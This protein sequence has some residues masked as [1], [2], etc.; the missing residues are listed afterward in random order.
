MFGAQGESFGAQLRRHREA[1]GLTQEQLAERAGLTVNGVSQLE[2]GERRRPYPHTV[3]ALAAALGLSEP[4]RAA[5][6]GMVPRRGETAPTEPVATPL[7]AA[8][9]AP[10]TALL[11][12]E[13]DVGAVADLLREARLVTLTGPGGVGKTRLGLAV[14][15]AIADR[16]PNSVAFVPLAALTDPALVVPAIA[17]AVGVREAGGLSPGDALHAALRARRLL[18]VLDNVEHLLAAV[19]AIA[20]L[21]AACPGLT[22]LATSRAPLRVRGEREYPVAPL[23]A[24]ALER[25]PTAAEVAAAPAARL[26]VERARAVAPAFALSD[27]NAAAVAAI[28]RRLDGLPLA[29]ELAAGWVRLLPPTA[30]LARLDRALPL[31]TAGPRDLPERQ[32][33]MR[34]TVAWSY[35]LLEPAE[36]RLFRRLAVFAGGWTLAAAE[37]V[38]A[39]AAS[40]DDPAA[41]HAL[42]AG[43]SSLL[44]KSLLVQSM[45]ASMADGEATDEPRFS[46]LETIRAYGLEQLAASGEEK[47]VRDRHA[48]HYLA[49]AEVAGPALTGGEQAAWLDRLGREHDNL[50]A[51]LDWLLARGHAE[52][53]ARLGWDLT[54]FWYIRGHVSEGRR[55]MER[56]LA[57][58]AALRPAGRARALTVGAVLAFQQGDFDEADALL[59]ESIRL[60]RDAGDRLVLASALLTRGYAAVGRGEGAQAVAYA[61]ESARLFRAFG[62]RWGAGLALTVGVQIATA[63]GELD[64]ANVDLD[65]AE[66]LLRAAGAPWGLALVLNI[67]VMI[68]Q[69]QGDHAG[70]VDLLR[71]SIGLSRAIGD[72][73]ALYFGLVSLGGALT[74]TGQGVRAARLFGAAEALR[75]R[76]GVTMPNAAGYALYEQQL[77]ALRTQLDTDTLAA[78]WAAGRAL[79]LA[80][81]IAEALA[82]DE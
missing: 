29:L 9:P 13:G 25:V 74:M 45:P 37:A 16:Y 57:C 58:G 17:A 42:L 26:F 56:V 21:L 31:L 81:A 65:Q 70:T 51:A 40:P 12:R 61:E 71:E 18:L 24:P 27:T 47:Q 32:R 68:A 69:L 52:G 66:A 30:L 48:A 41:A 22:I 6:A 59:D 15:E 54:W 82:E 75:E 34:D 44:E 46:M 67:R 80:A 2:R 28:C 49:L 50:R 39:G 23:V 43:L 4:E 3:Q 62:D 60:A 33:T 11:G 73:A 38:A 79:S 10:A 76:T 63:A 77:A 35:D 7:A 14:A 72:T 1:A 53:A 55:W 64:R 36:Q 5:L 19:P 8:L 78:A 20:G